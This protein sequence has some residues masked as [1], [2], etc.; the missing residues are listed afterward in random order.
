MPQ[1]IRALRRMCGTCTQKRPSRPQRAPPIASFQSGCLWLDP[2]VWDSAQLG[3][4]KGE[5]VADT[6]CT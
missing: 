6:S 2:I 5:C 4:A 3:Q 1:R